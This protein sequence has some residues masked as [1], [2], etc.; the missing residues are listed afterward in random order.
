MKLLLV[1]A[2][3]AVGRALSDQMQQRGIEAVVPE[4]E[5]DVHDPISAARVITR[6][7]PDQVINLV[8][9]GAGSQLAD[10]RAEQ[11]PERC[12]E[13]N[14][15]YPALL[16]QVCDHL[17]IPL[18]HLSSSHVFSGGKKLAYTEQDKTGPIGVYGHT[19]LAGEQ[20]IADT[21]ES[22]VIVRAGWLF[23]QGQDEF[24][25]SWLQEVVETDGSITTRRCRFSPTP[26]EDLARVLL[27]IALQV[28]CNARAWGVYHYCA[29]DSRKESEFAR[30]VIRMAARR[31]ESIYRLLDHL[32]VSPARVE[33][34]DM[35]NA[36][37]SSKKVF[38][39]FGIKQRPWQASLE[40]LITSYS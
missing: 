9:Y 28:D 31:D 25:R 2:D 30:E 17:T 6:G 20:A 32:S 38:D 13:L 19:A 1:G 18:L 39:T 8:S 21:M 27:A 34:P 24:I 4:E 29:A 16:A 15:Q 40:K 3:S 26:V 22:W 36:T 14:H 10:Y 11:E 23:G 33:A 37:L 7:E 5:I 35:A 12:D